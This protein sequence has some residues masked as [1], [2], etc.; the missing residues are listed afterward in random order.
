MSFL[1]PT[2]ISTQDHLEIE[3]IRDD[4]VVLKSGIVA[5]V[6]QTNGLNFDLLSE[7]EQDSKILAFAALLNSLDFQVQVV[8][9]TDRT[10]I[11]NYITKLEVFKLKQISQAL[12]RQIEIYIKFIKNL[13]L[14]KEILDKSFYVAIPEV[15]GEVHRTSMVK[16]I[17]GKKERITNIRNL[18]EKAKPPLFSKRNHLFK[19]FK[20]IGIFS[21]QMANEELIRLYY[22]MY[23][24]DKTGVS[25]MQFT[26][27]EFTSSLVRPFNN[28]DKLDKT[29][30]MA[31][32]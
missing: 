8:I 6:I 18:L 14:N 30:L 10:D 31:N 17:F 21:R 9:K 29:K 26:T 23:D 28:E 7:K 15:V 3:D 27:T 22:S 16:Q 4:L 1:N 19:Q 20:R 11:S 5:M 12:R 2:I 24:P 32:N 13:T 25:R